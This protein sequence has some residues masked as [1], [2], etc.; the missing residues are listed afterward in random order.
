MKKTQHWQEQK[1]I[2]TMKSKNSMAT[3]DK[4]IQAY[5]SRGGDVSSDTDVD[6]K[7]ALIR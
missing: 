5:F 1:K 4:G 7:P 3:I 2:L 6:W